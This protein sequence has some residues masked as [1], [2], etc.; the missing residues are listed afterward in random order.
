MRSRIRAR[1]CSVSRSHVDCVMPSLYASPC[2]E[3][4]ENLRAPARLKIRRAEADEWRRDAQHGGEKTNEPGEKRCRDVPD[5]APR[6]SFRGDKNIACD[7]MTQCTRA[8]LDLSGNCGFKCR[9]KRCDCI[10]AFGS[11]AK[12]LPYD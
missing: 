3:I 2:Y 1:G 10:A 12:F 9:C 6:N 5:A 7:T 4:L 8:K 11:V